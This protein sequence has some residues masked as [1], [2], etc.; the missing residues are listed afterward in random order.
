VEYL[1]EREAEFDTLLQTVASFS[2]PKTN[3]S[4][5]SHE[6]FTTLHFLN[7]ILTIQTSYMVLFRKF[8][9]MVQDG[10]AP[11]P[12]ANGKIVSLEHI[13]RWSRDVTPEML[14]QDYCIY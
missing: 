13:V 8:L 5:L 1:T 7:R 9:V 14:R 4:E 3:Y 2:R 11:E 6:D 10:I 12:L